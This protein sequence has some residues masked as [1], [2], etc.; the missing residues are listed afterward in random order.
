MI[1]PRKT[2]LVKYTTHHLQLR[3]RH[4]CGPAEYDAVLYHQKRTW[5]T[6]DFV[7]PGQKDMKN[8]N[9]EYWV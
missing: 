6:K 5:K 7:P 2:E 9:R 4:Q 8:S 3:R 1:D